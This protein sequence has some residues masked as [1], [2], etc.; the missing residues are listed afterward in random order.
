MNSTQ[1][2]V[3]TLERLQTHNKY[4]RLE[5]YKPYPYQLKFHNAKGWRTDKPAQVKAL[6]AANQIGKTLSVCAEDAMHITGLYPIWWEGH[7]FNRPITAIIGTYTNEQ[8][9][10]LLQHELFGDPMDPDSFGSGFIPKRLIGEKSNKPGIPNAVDSV[11][12]KHTS[13]GW[14]KIFFRSYEVGARKFMGRR[15]DYY[16]YDEEPPQDIY[17]QAVRGTLSRQ[18]SVI[19]MTFTP[20]HGTTELYLNLTR[21]KEIGRCVQKASWDDAPHFAD[22]EIRARELRKIPE[23]QRSLRSQGLPMMGAGMIYPYSDKELMF[24]RFEIPR[25][26]PRIKGIDFGTSH[27]FALI[28]G[29]LDR[30]ADTFY[31]YDAIKKEEMNIATMAAAINSRDKWIPVAWPHD[32]NKRDPGSGKAWREILQNF[33]HECNMLP[34]CYSH[35]SREGEGK[36]GQAIWPGIYEIQ[37]WMD[38]G[39]LKVA[40]HLSDW[41]DEKNFYHEGSNGKPVEINDDLMDASR[42]CF[43]MRRFATTR[44]MPRQKKPRSVG[45]RNW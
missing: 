2:L 18:D 23:R 34:E 26:W 13:G 15:G 30:D 14:S 38:E 25:Y 39:R 10:D 8:T 31:I 12:V 5:T 9:R 20:E 45:A 32:L 28:C 24:E 6:I 3:E 21:E 7:R 35:D 16:H 40:S 43:G 42:Y 22:P 17:D 33:P 37:E 44:P 1:E 11:L 19:V 41:F 29:A 27:A 36:G 4:N